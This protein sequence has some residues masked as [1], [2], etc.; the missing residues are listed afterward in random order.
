[1]DSLERQMEHQRE[2][3]QSTLDRT[4]EGRAQ[5]AERP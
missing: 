1:M 2:Q 3:I 5:N 4:L